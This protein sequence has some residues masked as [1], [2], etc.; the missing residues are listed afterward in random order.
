MK[1]R[2][3]A[4]VLTIAG[5]VCF[6]ASNISTLKETWVNAAL[7]GA[8]VLLTGFGLYRLWKTGQSAGA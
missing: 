4:V 7:T 3:A 6:A 8:G 2:S 5:L 1:G